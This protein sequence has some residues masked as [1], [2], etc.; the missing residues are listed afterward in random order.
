MSTDGGAM[1]AMSRGVP[2]GM[3][4][5]KATTRSSL[6]HVPTGSWKFDDSVTAVFDDMLQRSIPQYDVM[7]E[8]VH[9]IAT[10]FCCPDMLVIDLGASSG[11]SIAALVEEETSRG[12]QPSARFVAIERSGPMLNELRRRFAACLEPTGVVMVIDHDLRH[13][14][15]PLNLPASLVLSILTMQFVPMEYR[16]QLMRAIYDALAP[17][18]AFVLVEKILGSTAALDELFVRHYLDSK[19]SNGY[20][21]EEIER[22]RLS[23][24]GVLVPVTA[25]WNEEMLS[26][27]GFSQI[28]C[29]WRWLNFAGWLALKT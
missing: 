7:R 14:F 6:G 19:L 17:G 22:K 16:Q 2:S 11:E 1:T 5:S 24:E 29:F 21:I 10:D 23:L 9:H 20:S 26:N 25:R 12:R 28:D 3:A 27:A 4:Q 15:P 18:G 13:G 8:T